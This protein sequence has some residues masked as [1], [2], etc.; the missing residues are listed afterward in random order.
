VAN[1]VC[2]SMFFLHLQLL[3][4]VYLELLKGLDDSFF[5]EMESNSCGW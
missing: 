3:L 2:V 1:N 5:R 4:N